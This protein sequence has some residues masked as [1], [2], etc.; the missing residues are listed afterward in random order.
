M[1]YP[2]STWTRVWGLFLSRPSCCWL[3]TGLRFHPDW[4]YW[5]TGIG[6]IL[7]WAWCH[8]FFSLSGLLH[9][10]NNVSDTSKP[11]LAPSIRYHKLWCQARALLSPVSLATKMS[12]S[13]L[14]CYF[15]SHS[16]AFGFQSS[17]P[18]DNITLTSTNRKIDHSLFRISDWHLCSCS[19]HSQYRAAHFPYQSCAWWY[20][21]QILREEL[22]LFQKCMNYL[23]RFITFWTMSCPNGLVTKLIFYHMF[24]IVLPGS[25]MEFELHSSH[26][27]T[28]SRT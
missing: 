18:P 17:T 20:H 21:F 2:I 23:S 15:S 12:A 16:A 13:K 6:H 5:D 19:C 24:L 22:F 8:Y 11:Q 27:F 1:T 7:G 3:W 25:I 28:V 9:F 10:I 4:F 14:T 26:F